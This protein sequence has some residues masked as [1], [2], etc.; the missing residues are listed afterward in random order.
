MIALGAAT[1]AAELTQKGNLFIR[2]DGGIS[3]RA[4]PRHEL[5]PISVRIEGTVRVPS[6]ERPSLRRIRIAVNRAGR[7][8]TQGLPVCGRN[9]ID[10]ATPSEALAACGPSL[11][12]AG[13][14][15]ARTSLADD[16]SATTARADVLLF[17]SVRDGRPVILGHVYQ[18][19]PTPIARSI[20][21]AI[22]RTGGAFGT[23]ITGEIPKG[24]NNHGYLKSIFLQLERRYVYRGRPRSYLSA[25][26]AAPTG[27][28][29]ATFPFARA[30]MTFED[31]RTLSSTLVRSCKVK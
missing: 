5:A 22:R 15:V 9:Q 18:T 10:P 24:I 30:S 17:N 26:C 23:V 6:G 13:G 12:G 19:Q 29:G 14:I 28:P 4:L 21:F 7:L 11:V 25:A 3:P 1:A 16:Q 2:F 27:F 31:G 20:V 8:T